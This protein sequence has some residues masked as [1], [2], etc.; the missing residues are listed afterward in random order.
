MQKKILLTLFFLISFFLLAS[1]FSVQAFT[2][3]SDPQ[4]IVMNFSTINELN[5]AA[6]ESEWQ[7]SIKPQI[8]A[9]IHELRAALPEG[10]KERKL[11]WSTLEEYMNFPLDSPSEQSIYVI[12]MRRILEIAEEENLPV[13]LPLNGFQW[14][15]ELPELYNW[16]D[17]DGTHTPQSFFDRQKTK[18]FKERFIKG[19]NPENKWNVEWQNYETPMNLNF[20]DW[21][22]GGFRLA[23]PPNLVDHKR[24]KLSYRGV[25]EARY[26]AILKELAKKLTV[27]EKEKKSYLFAGITIGT[28]ISL[29]ASIASDDFSP[30]GYRGIQDIL[31]M[32]KDPQCGTKENFTHDQIQ[33]ARKKVVALYLRDLSQIAV[34]LGVPKQRIYTHVW[35]EVQPGDKKYVD[36]IGAAFNLY[37]R[38]GMSFYGFAENPLS[39]GTW[40]GALQDYGNPGWGGVEYSANKTDTAWTAGMTNTFNNQTVPGKVVD[41]YNWGEH[42]NTPAIPVLAR[43]LNQ[44]PKQTACVLPEMQTITKSPVNNPRVL[45]WQFLKTTEGIFQKKSTLSLVVVPD[46]FVNSLTDGK[47]IADLSFKQT[48]LTLPKLAPGIY[49]WYVV[50]DGCDGKKKHYSNPGVFTI[51]FPTEVPNLV[52]WTIFFEKKMQGII[53]IFKTLSGG[54]PEKTE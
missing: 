17:P 51:P 35:G 6:P 47:K 53:S 49:S 41:I 21:G 22:G 10:T 54:V 48:Q 40:K 25:L 50:V 7:K 23:P 18:D 29:N 8:L 11:A 19:Y 26:T 52:K 27:W 12:K 13:F 15:D 43:I 32:Q 37:S 16:W 3:D 46:F 42:K 38:P 4:Y 14:W 20:R 33:N 24:T 5:W 9:Q 34:S 31:C 2:I 39:L 1:S 36:Y 30:Y 44:D 45:E 28:E